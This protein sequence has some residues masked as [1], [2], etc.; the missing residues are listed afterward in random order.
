MT[1]ADKHPIRMCDEYEYGDALAQ[2][3]IKEQKK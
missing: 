1:H 3:D 2:V